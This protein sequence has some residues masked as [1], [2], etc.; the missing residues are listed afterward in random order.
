MDSLIILSILCILLAVI[1]SCIIFISRLTKSIKPRP[2]TIVVSEDAVAMLTNM[3]PAKEHRDDI[4]AD[5]R[6]RRVK[7]YGTSQRNKNASFP[8]WQSDTEY[9]K[10]N[11]LI[12]WFLSENVIF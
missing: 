2:T 6:W 10:V 3:L 4:K 1:V 7:L 12:F 5:N 11:W 9:Q 8:S